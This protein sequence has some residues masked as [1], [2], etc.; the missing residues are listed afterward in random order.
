MTQYFATI[1]WARLD[2]R[3]TDNRYSR[4]H[5]WEFDGG[6]TVPASSSPHVVPVP[7]SDPAN[8]DPEEAFVAALSSCHMLWFLSIAAK[9]GFVV[10]TYTD[11]AQ[12]FMD[13]NE[14]NQLVMTKIILAPDIVFSG[15]KCPS[16]ADVDSLHHEAHK[17]C[18]LANSVKTEIT[19]NGSWSYA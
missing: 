17:N 2:A 8:V 18:Y 1:T 7:Y 6:V 15:P 13:K 19:I 3:F 9:Q 16:Q 10:D 14:V 12:G 5:Q 11:N 4:I